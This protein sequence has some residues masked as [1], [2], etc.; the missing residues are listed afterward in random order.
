MT[1]NVLFLCPHNAAKSVAAAAFFARDAKNRGLAVKTSTAGTDPDTHVLPV[2]RE[3]LET[4]G[5][6]V[7]QP[8]RKVTDQ[9]LSNA[10]VIINIGCKLDALP[11]PGPVH[12]WQIPNFSDD[13]QAAFAAL[14][15]HTTKLVNQLASRPGTTG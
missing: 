13:P 7:D 11:A 5:L 9:N 2:V 14:E 15:S 4:E 8:P 6:P 10:D 3:R 12:D 1:I